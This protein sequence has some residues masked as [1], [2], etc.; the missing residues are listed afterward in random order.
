M[1]LGDC[2]AYGGECYVNYDP[3]HTLTV[4]QHQSQHP[5]INTPTC[6]I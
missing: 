5:L 3:T 2:W 1:A 6:K 4:H